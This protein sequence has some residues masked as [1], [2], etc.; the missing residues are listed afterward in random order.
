MQSFDLPTNLPLPVDDGACAHLKAG[1]RFPVDILVKLQSTSQRPVD[2]TSQPRTIIYFYPRTGVPNQK[3]P[4]GWDEIP[5]ARGCTPESCGFRDHYQELQKLG[6]NVYD[7]ST[8]TTEYQKEAAD[9]LNLP[10]D[11]LSDEKLQ[12]LHQL[13]LPYFT[14]ADLDNVPLIKR[15]TIV[16]RHDAIEH[17]FY[18]IFPPDQHCQEVIN[19]LKEHPLG[20]SVVSEIPSSL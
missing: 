9:R 15:L 14:L 6:A 11:L 17:V 7:C 12:L 2:I 5:G 16:L 13:N 18:P 1:T 8:Q 3:L 19:W 4:N 20:N 10:F